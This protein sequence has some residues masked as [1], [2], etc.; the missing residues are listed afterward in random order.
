MQHHFAAGDESHAGR[1]EAH[2]VVSRRPHTALVGVQRKVLKHTKQSVRSH[3]ALG[4]HWETEH[5]RLVLVLW[6]CILGS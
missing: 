1:H 2:H 4:A 3:L 5:H 6:G